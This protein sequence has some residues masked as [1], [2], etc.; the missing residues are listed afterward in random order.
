MLWPEGVMTKLRP[1]TPV[2]CI[3]APSGFSEIETTD[4][5]DKGIHSSSIRQQR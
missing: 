1:A 4:L 3:L 5:L 2:H